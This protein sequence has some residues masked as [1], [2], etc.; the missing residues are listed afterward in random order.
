MAVVTGGRGLEGGV[1]AGGVVLEE[2]EGVGGGGF[3]GGSG[4]VPRRAVRGGPNLG[5]A[6]V[7]SRIGFISFEF[8]D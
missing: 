7:G 3:V 2:E 8:H 6:V 4:R 5:T 1:W